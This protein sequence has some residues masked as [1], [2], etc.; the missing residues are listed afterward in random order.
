MNGLEWRWEDRDFGFRFRNGTA[1]NADEL[2]QGRVPG[3][4]YVVQRSLRKLPK[5]QADLIADGAE[6]PTG[7]RIVA[8]PWQGYER[9]WDWISSDDGI[10]FNWAGCLDRDEISRR[11][12]EGVQRAME[13]VI[14]L[15]QRDQPVPISGLLVQ[16]IHVELMGTIYPFAGSWRTVSLHKGDGPTKWPLPVCG[17]APIMEVLE[18]DVFCKTPVVSDDDEEVFATVAEVMGE[19]IALHPF[20]EGNGRTSFIVGNLLLMQN[21]LLPMSAYDRRGD[22]SR[23]YSAC[24]RA[25]IYKDY[26]G[27]TSLLCEWQ[28]RAITRWEERNEQP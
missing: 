1:R 23:Y 13:F 2:Y 4:F 10:P 12:D 22:E 15:L 5:E 28:D 8:M 14:R 21:G 3:E 25:R 7:P 9:E 26:E 24:E 27:L 16:Q 17:I 19:L 6:L 18:R 20:R 11:E